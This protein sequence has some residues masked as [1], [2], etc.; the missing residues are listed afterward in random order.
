MVQLAAHIIRMP[1]L[2][3]PVPPHIEEKHGWRVFRNS[4]CIGAIDG[5]HYNLRAPGELARVYRNRKGWLSFNVCAVCDFHGRFCYIFPGWEGS[6]NDQKVFNDAI[7]KDLNIPEGTY[8]LADAGYASQARLLTPFRGTRYHLQ[9]WSTSSRKPETPNELYNLRH[10]GFRMII[11]RTF[12][13]HKGSYRILTGGPRFGVVSMNAI[14][15]AT[16]ALHNWRIDYGDVESGVDIEL[17][18]PPPERPT[19][20]GHR[21]KEGG[22]N[23]YWGQKRVALAQASWDEYREN[24]QS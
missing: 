2:E 3:T 1:A 11:E 12:G 21:D 13:A 22:D 24:A 6:A 4:G 20:L 7:S 14:I 23:G 8:L 18:E 5:S 15:R 16:A 17:P 19:Q 10:S 9:E